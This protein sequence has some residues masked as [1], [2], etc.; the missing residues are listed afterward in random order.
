MSKYKE[1]ILEDFNVS[2]EHEFQ[3]D[4]T[5]INND[6]TYKVNM[7]ICINI[8]LYLIIFFLLYYCILNG[9]NIDFFKTFMT[10]LVL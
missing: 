3:T 2:R 6:D 5:I 9:I 10:Y 7:L 4:F 1:F 8:C